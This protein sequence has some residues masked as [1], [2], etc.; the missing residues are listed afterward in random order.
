M[1][2]IHFP[3]DEYVLSIVAKYCTISEV[4]ALMM[5]IDKNGYTSEGHN[6]YGQILGFIYYKFLWVTMDARRSYIYIMDTIKGPWPPGE[7][8]ISNSPYYSYMYAKEFIKG[9]W[10]PGEKAIS[11]SP[12]FSYCYAR[13]IIEDIWP[14]GERAIS[15]RAEYSLYYAVYLVKGRWLPG[16][17]AIKRNER[18]WK[19]YNQFN[20]IGIFDRFIYWALDL[21]RR[22]SRWSGI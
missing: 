20:S 11:N 8:A 21:F 3:F 14:P 19:I 22:V 2:H 16:E 17:K 1:R 18:Y 4:P 10:P 12:R 6:I 5:I 9:P 13:V 7:E 15:T